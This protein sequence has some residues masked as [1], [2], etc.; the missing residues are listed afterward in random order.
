VGVRA[1]VVAGGALCVVGC[2]AVTAALPRLWAYDSRHGADTILR[3]SGSD[4]AGF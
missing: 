2:G 1:S 4:V 3:S